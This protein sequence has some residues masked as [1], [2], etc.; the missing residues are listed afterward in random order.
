MKTI[1]QGVIATFA[2][3]LVSTTQ[4]LAVEDQGLQVQGTN[5]VLSWPSLGYEYYMIEY[6]PT[7]DDGTPFVQL[8]N[9]F[10]ANSTN[11]TIYEIPCSTLNALGGGYPAASSPLRGPPHSPRP[12]LV[13]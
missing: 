5:L 1:K 12:Q 2:L 10:P 3:L 6:R 7:L 9:C 8:T 13:P 4:L 11:R